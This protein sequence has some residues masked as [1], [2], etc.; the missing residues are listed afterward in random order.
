M[1]DI[2]FIREN[3]TQVKEAAKNKNIE[4]D[5]DELLRLD[6][7]RRDFQLQLNE[8]RQKR[9]ELAAAGKEGKP[10]PE[11]IEAGKKIKADIAEL[12]NDFERIELQYKEELSRVPNVIN[13]NVPIGK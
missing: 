1:L 3:T 10:T 2:K 12:E 4:V 9:N 7:K 11:Q 8:L 5:I 13:P 6:E